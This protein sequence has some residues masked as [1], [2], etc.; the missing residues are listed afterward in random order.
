VKRGIRIGL[1]VLMIV[2]VIALALSG[3]AKEEAPA[4]V[5]PTPVTPT[6]VT[7]TPVKPTPVAPTPAEPEVFDWK[8]TSYF[9]EAFHFVQ[10][11]KHFIE[12]VEDM[13]GGRIQLGWFPVGALVGTYELLDAAGKGTVEVCGEWPTTWGGTNRG[14]E[15]LGSTQML[16]N[17][18]DMQ[19]WYFAGGGLEIGQELYA[20]YNTKWFT[21]APPTS[22]GGFWTNQLVEHPADLAG[23]KIRLSGAVSGAVLEALGATPIS[24]AGGEIYTAMERGTL[25]ACEYSSPCVDLTMGFHEVAKYRITPGWYQTSCTCGQMV[26]MDKWNELPDDLQAI[27]ET[28]AH[29]T[30]LWYYT[31]GHHDNAAALEAFKEAGVITTTYTPE[32]I[33]LLQD[34]AWPEMV[35]LAEESEDYARIL[36]HMIAFLKDMESWKTE[37]GTFGWGQVLEEYPAIP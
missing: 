19:I 13:S 14:F 20:R 11:D 21:H 30:Y 26:N 34:L 6:P 35:K 31:K 15:L 24:L 3:C 32:D 36:K 16:M 2:S 23:L 27:W 9:P 22:E 7:P 33:K 17:S 18:P 29:A 5:T 1:A 12:L 25:D 28:A 8:M 10:A 37:M 4:P